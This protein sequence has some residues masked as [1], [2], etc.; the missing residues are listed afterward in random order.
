M[1]VP[2]GKLSTVTPCGNVVRVLAG[3]ATA[4][5]FLWIE[6][7]GAGQNLGGGA[8]SGCGRVPAH[9]LWAVGWGCLFLCS[10]VVLATVGAQVQ[11]P[12]SRAPSSFILL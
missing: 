4:V 2:W 1:A 8:G 7:T 9:Q 10:P 5:K 6:K 11:G 12:Y 3:S